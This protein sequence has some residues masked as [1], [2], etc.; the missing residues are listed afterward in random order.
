LYLATTTRP[1]QHSTCPSRV[2]QVIA[3]IARQHWIAGNDCAAGMAGPRSVVPPSMST[4]S[5]DITWAVSI[6]CSCWWGRKG[7]GRA[8]QSKGLFCVSKTSCRSSTR[9][10]GTRTSHACS[11]QRVM[12]VNGLGVL[13][14]PRRSPRLE[15]PT[16]TSLTATRRATRGKSRSSTPP[17]E[18]YSTS[19][20]AHQDHSCNE[21][22]PDSEYGAVGPRGQPLIRRV[23]PTHLSLDVSRPS[24]IHIREKPTDTTAVPLPRRTG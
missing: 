21:K 7:V 15:Y 12:W 4:R 11:A 9:R 5:R 8:S 20:P 23:R 17:P 3:S 2:A 16:R 6:T 18:Q 13:L 24:R 14:V 19:R 10:H 22:T 1:V